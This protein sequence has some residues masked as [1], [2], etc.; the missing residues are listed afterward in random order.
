MLRTTTLLQFVGRCICVAVLI[1]LQDR[2]CCW[3][4]LGRRRR[5]WRHHF[6]TGFPVTLPCSRWIHVTIVYRTPAQEPHRLNSFLLMIYSHSLGRWMHAKGFLHYGIVCS[7]SCFIDFQL[8]ASRSKRKWVLRSLD[9]LLKLL[10][11][12]LLFAERR[13]I[14]VIGSCIHGIIRKTGRSWTFLSTRETETKFSPSA[15]DRR[16]TGLTLLNGVD[17][18]SLGVGVLGAFMESIFIWPARGFFPSLCPLK[19]DRTWSVIY[20]KNVESKKLQRQRYHLLTKGGIVCARPV[21]TMRKRDWRP[22]FF[23]QLVRRT[24][25]SLR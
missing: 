18:L 19:R 16:R 12:C 21:E 5:R 25:N 7:C 6:S 20:A 24:T 4:W 15:T 17:W 22:P 9:W 8:I 1:V 14:V 3:Y 13:S 23:T 2:C 11:W 10:L